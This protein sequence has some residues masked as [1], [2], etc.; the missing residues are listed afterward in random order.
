MAKVMQKVG[1]T[2]HLIDYLDSS[3]LTNCKT[4]G[5]LMHC[6]QHILKIEMIFLLNCIA[7]KGVEFI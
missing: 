4:V 3:I 5:I 6:S 7:L 1:K 2:E